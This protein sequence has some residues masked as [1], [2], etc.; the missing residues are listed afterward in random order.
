VVARDTI[1]AHSP[2]T[3]KLPY[4]FVFYHSVVGQYQKKKAVFLKRKGKF[5]MADEE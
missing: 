1:F 2:L 4:L 3:A 5:K